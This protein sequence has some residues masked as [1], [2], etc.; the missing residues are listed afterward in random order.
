MMYSRKTGLNNARFMVASMK[1]PSLSCQGIVSIMA[2][3]Q[4]V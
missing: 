1:K 4:V 3:L 2:R